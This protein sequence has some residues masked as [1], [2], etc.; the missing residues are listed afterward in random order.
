MLKTT[1]LSYLGALLSSALLSLACGDDASSDMSRSDGETA[2]Q[3]DGP[4]ADGQPDGADDEMQNDGNQTQPLT[5]CAKYGGADNV[6]SVVKN[7]VIGA[8]AADCRVNSFFTELGSD[9]FTR[10][11]DCLTIQVQELFSCDGV[12]YAGA[13]ASNGLPCRSMATAHVGLGISDADFNALIE[14]VVLGLGGAGV[15]EDDI[16]AAAP[17]LLGMQDDIVEAADDDASTRGSCEAQ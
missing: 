4:D 13:E 3:T 2:M 9:A 16:M 17:A 6:A 11:E 5:L 7:D 14:D 8:I 12:T 10:V 15:E 1:Y